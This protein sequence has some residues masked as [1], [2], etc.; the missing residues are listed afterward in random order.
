M[1]VQDMHPV[2]SATVDQTM[3]NVDV[4]SILRFCTVKK[5]DND[6]D[7]MQE[8]RHTLALAFI[9]RLLTTFALRPAFE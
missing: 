4:S 8:L 6:A 1:N 5:N 9:R 3:L 2:S 7:Y